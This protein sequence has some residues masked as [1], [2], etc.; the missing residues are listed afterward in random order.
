MKR[1]GMAGLAITVLLAALFLINRSPE[2]APPGNLRAEPRY[3]W[4]SVRMVVEAKGR[5][6][7][8]SMWAVYEIYRHA[9]GRFSVEVIQ[10]ENAKFIGDGFKYDGRYAWLHTGPAFAEPWLLDPKG[11]DV[12]PDYVIDPA[13]ANAVAR[14][15][16]EG[17][18]EIQRSEKLLG[19]ETAVVTIPG[20]DDSFER[21][22]IDPETG[23][24]MAWEGWSRG[25]RT[26]YLKVLEIEWDPVIPEGIFEVKVPSKG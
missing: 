15:A 10:S 24:V 8:P 6:I 13:R 3:E 21:F 7:H 23:V 9:D 1:I 18:A 4:P 11:H 16:M 25:E 19:M 22:W 5:L 26:G 20:S 2:A 14:L 17:R 12:A